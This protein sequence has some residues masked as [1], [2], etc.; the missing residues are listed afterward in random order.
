MDANDF[1]YSETEIAQPQD[2]TRATRRLIPAGKAFVIGIVALLVATLLNAAAL[3][4]A[5]EAQRV[6]S[7]LRALTV[8][9]IRPVASFS[10]AVGL[11]VPRRT[12][13]Q[14]LG[15]A[16][17]DSDAVAI[18]ASPAT[19]PITPIPTST[20]VA[21]PPAHRPVSPEDPLRVYLAADSFGQTLGP[22]LV[23]VSADG[24]L[25]DVEFDFKISSGLMRPDFYDW[26]AHVRERLPEVDAEVAIAMFGGN[27]GQ[28]TFAEG[29]LQDIGS[30]VWIE[31]YSG[32]VA[33]MMDILSAAALEVYWIGL[34]ITGSAE[35]VD[36]FQMMNEIYRTEAEKRPNVTFLDIWSLF[37]DESGAYARYLR[38]DAGDLVM[39]RAA[40]HIH[41]DWAGAERLAGVVLERLT[42]DGLLTTVSS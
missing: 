40:D 31:V 32:R 8:S 17:V 10:A 41:F 19:P 6:G 35:H 7:P 28:E 24:G 33:E 13:D 12:I 23:N 5:A 18:V 22:S 20:T 21:T 38:N 9:M 26:P 34:P 29:E 36:K 16:E 1:D 4:E 25:V 42:A 2:S 3:L 14:A 30:P 11:D 27:D 15:R 37:E 39:M